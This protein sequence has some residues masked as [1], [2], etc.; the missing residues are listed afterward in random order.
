MTIRKKIGELYYWQLAFTRRNRA[1]GA[2][3]ALLI[4]AVCL[5]GMFYTMKKLVFIPP[6]LLSSCGR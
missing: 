3:L 2:I 6:C 4:V 5:Y 1:A